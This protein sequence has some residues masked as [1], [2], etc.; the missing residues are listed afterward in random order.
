MKE[1]TVED[2]PILIEMGRSFHASSSDRDIEFDDRGF[3]R[4]LTAMMESEKAC[5]FVADDG[6][7][8]GVVSPLPWLDKTYLVASEVLWRA[9]K[10]GARLQAR[11]IEWAREKG[12]SRIVISHREGRN[13]AFAR[14]LRRR[15]FVPYEHYYQRSI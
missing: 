12:A 13:E 11:F 7:I 10:S 8:C 9:K 15:G 4:M 1:A 3:G 6:F 2:L 5:I 14:L